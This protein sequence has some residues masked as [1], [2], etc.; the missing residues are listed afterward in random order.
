M[1]HK[2]PCARRAFTC[3]ICGGTF[4]FSMAY[5]RRGL[6]PTTCA[7]CE[8]G[9]MEKT[10]RDKVEKIPIQAVQWYP[11]KKVDGVREMRDRAWVDDLQGDLELHPGYWIITTEAGRKYVTDDVTFH[12]I[13]E[14]AA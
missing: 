3:R 5:E 11:G 8:G 1:G 9:I 4:D 13:Y 12:K 10:Y 2:W 14:V 7:N 6:V